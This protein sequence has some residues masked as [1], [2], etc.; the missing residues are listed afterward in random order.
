LVSL[1]AG[2]RA[3]FYKTGATVRLGGPDETASVST[4]EAGGVVGISLGFRRVHGVLELDG[5]YA[6]AKGSLMGFDVSVGG[7]VLSPAAAL[8]CTF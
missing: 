2:P 7:V 6:K 8:A 4:W 3:S 5:G 1:W